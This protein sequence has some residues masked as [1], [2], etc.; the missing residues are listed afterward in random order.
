MEY[1]GAQI[2]G[3]SSPWRLIFEGP[4]CGICVAY[5]STGFCNFEVGLG[6]FS[7]GAHSTDH[8]DKN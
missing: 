3:A 4:Q 6:F 1:M 7:G 8:H 5:N 2:P